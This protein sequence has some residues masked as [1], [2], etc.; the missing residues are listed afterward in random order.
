MQWG[1][2]QTFDNKAILTRFFLPFIYLPF[3]TV[4]CSARG[5][6][7]TKHTGAYDNLTTSSMHVATLSGNGVT[8]LNGHVFWK[9]VGF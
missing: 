3:A 1:Q 4:T 6:L 9:V 7:G 5:H 2:A 8:F